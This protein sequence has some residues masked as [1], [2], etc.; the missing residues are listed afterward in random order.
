MF[1]IPKSTVH[2]ISFQTR[3][4]PPAKLLSQPEVELE[5]NF[6]LLDDLKSPVWVHLKHKELL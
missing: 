5:D 4:K 1:F 2:N 3:R 6:D